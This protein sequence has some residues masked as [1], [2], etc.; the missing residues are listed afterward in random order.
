[1]KLRLVSCCVF[2]GAFCAC[3]TS[4][5]KEITEREQEAVKKLDELAKIQENNFTKKIG[6]LKIMD[7][8]ISR[9]L[10]T[11][12]ERLKGIDEEATK[13]IMAWE[14][15]QIALAES[16]VNNRL[17][18]RVS[19][20]DLAIREVG[21]ENAVARLMPFFDGYRKLNLMV[22]PTVQI[23]GEETVGSG[24]IIHS[25]PAPGGS[26]NF[27]LTAYH[28]IRNI[29]SEGGNPSALRMLF[30]RDGRRE[31]AIGTILAHEESIDV[32][33]VRCVRDA[34]VHQTVKLAS[35]LSL[36][37]VFAPVY[38]VGCPLGNDP[39]PTDGDIASML[40]LVGSNRYWMVNAPAYFGNSGGGVFLAKTG[41][42][43]G[44]YSKIYTHGRGRPTVISHMGLVTPI[45]Q[46]LEFLDRT[47]YGFLFRAGATY[48]APAES[49][50]AQSQPAESQPTDITPASQPILSVL[51]NR[52]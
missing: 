44:L 36:L 5:I 31:E 3:T 12:E 8:E 2:F 9:H 7:S 34:P 28:V 33:L 18:E 11:W 26:E 40:S 13:R 50:P 38:V 30:Y 25:R 20:L 6:E 39:I 51:R 52:D 16:R 37:S 15:E 27:I 43:I 21:A 1:M 42:L 10:L 19:E 41:E 29:Q 35:S 46:I 14:Q 48:P 49:Q 32:A 24:I 45:D 17:G 47:G 23:A 22:Y 4:P